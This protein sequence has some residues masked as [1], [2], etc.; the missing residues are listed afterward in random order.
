MGEAK[1]ADSLTERC[2]P[3]SGGRAFSSSLWQE[4]ATTLTAPRGRWGS[5]VHST[6]EEQELRGARG[7][8]WPQCCYGEPGP[9]SWNP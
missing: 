2:L 6:D 9:V 1:G 7:P 8:A 4:C 3:P 5:R